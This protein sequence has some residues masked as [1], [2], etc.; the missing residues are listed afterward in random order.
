M[1]PSKKQREQFVRT[2]FD[3]VARRYDL[4]NRLISFHLDTVW[5]R[6]AVQSLKLKHRPA[7]VLDLGT[8]TGDLA[9]AAASELGDGGRVIGLDFSLP[10]LRIAQSKKA[11][12]FGRPIAYVSGSAL[13]PPLKTAAFDAVMTAFVLR[14]VADLDVFF[15]EAY[16]LL[17]PGGQF[18]SVDMFPPS[19]TL[20]PLLYSVYFY[21]V[22]PWIGARVAREGAA[23]RYL[24]ESVKNFHPPEAIGRILE[25]SGFQSVGIQ[26]MMRGAVCLHSAKK[27]A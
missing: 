4:L 2:T 8:G 12:F 21:R 26:K 23:Y 25:R 13:K 16:R 15:Q 18:A 14:N 1:T 17:K 11:A 3:R 22:M 24:S 9:L 6:K 5:R 7:V 27:P 20:F 19:G 10:M